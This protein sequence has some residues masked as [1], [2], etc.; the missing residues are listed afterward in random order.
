M[1]IPSAPPS[2]DGG[3]TLFDREGEKLFSVST[4]PSS[5]AS[6]MSTDGRVFVVSNVTGSGPD[7][8]AHLSWYNISTSRQI[9]SLALNYAAYVDSLSMSTDGSLVVASGRGVGNFTYIAAF[10]SQGRQLW[11]HFDPERQEGGGLSIIES[12][13]A[14]S[15]DGGYV[16]AGRRDNVWDPTGHSHLPS[17]GNNNGI[18][19]FAREG[20]VLW[21]YTVPDWVWNVAISGTGEYVI[22][23]SSLSVYLLNKAGRL[24]WSM[25][26]DNGIVAI[27][28]TGQEFIAGHYGGGLFLGG[29]NGTYWQTGVDGHAQSRCLTQEGYRSPRTVVVS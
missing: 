10:D 11:I 8:L 3:A 14:T 4:T 13:V 7:S 2:N 25:P 17:A 1:R 24:Q 18:I 19:F 6:A 15:G 23:G 22:A 28:K 29:A 12:T 26:V 27:S 20:N 5:V 16:A 21:N 9:R